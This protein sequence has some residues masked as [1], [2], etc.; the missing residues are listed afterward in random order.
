MSIR[1][2]DEFQPYKIVETGAVLLDLLL[3]EINI[4]KIKS[5]G[6]KKENLLFE[7][8]AIILEKCRGLYVPGS[9]IR[10]SRVCSYLND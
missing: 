5:L 10:A 7:L 4:S 1:A 2:F 9:L 6:Q 3:M 8:L